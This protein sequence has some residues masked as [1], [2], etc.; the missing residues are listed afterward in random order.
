MPKVYPA[1]LLALSCAASNGSVLPIRQ[2]SEQNSPR[3]MIFKF[4]SWDFQ[5]VAVLSPKNPKKSYRVY[6]YEDGHSITL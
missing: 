3:L 6:H 4:L 2:I 1:T 5:N